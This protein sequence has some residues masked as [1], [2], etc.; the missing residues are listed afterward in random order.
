MDENEEEKTLKNKKSNVLPVVIITLVISGTLGFFGG[1][2][3]QQKKTPEFFRN[4][5][6][7]SQDGRRQFG[8]GNANLGLRPVSGE[9]LQ[10]DEK[11]I[12][13][14]LPDGSSKIVILS[15]SSSINKT[16]KGS[17]EDLKA[18]IK[19]TVFGT[20]NSDGSIS[21]QNIQIGGEVFN[22][23]IGQ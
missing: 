3:Y 4:F 14:K 5:Q 16:E 17:K 7:N 12:T 10:S 13:V 11:S 9:I 20:Q 6:G 23:R 18:G 15:D 19:V 21:A 8:N 22:Q 2:K 1:M